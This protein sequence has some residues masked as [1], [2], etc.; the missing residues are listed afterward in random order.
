M[1]IG[2]TLFVSPSRR[3][4]AAGIAALR[5]LLAE[6]GYSVVSVTLRDCLHLKTACTALD[7]ETIL[8]NPAWVD[9]APLAGY[10]LIPV[11]PEEP[12]AANTLRVHD[13]VLMSAAFPRTQAIVQGLGYAVVA[14]D[15]SEFQKAEGALTCMSLVI[16]EFPSHA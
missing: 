8:L 12:L 9:T 15:T 14:V 1:R 5:S 4:N 10:R 11:A 3:T 13:T 7:A 6:W 2:R 16:A